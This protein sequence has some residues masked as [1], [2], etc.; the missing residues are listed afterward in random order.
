MICPETQKDIANAS[1]KEVL[2]AIIDDV[3]DNL[4]GILVDESCDVSDKE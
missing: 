2:K 4:F 3:G 1:A